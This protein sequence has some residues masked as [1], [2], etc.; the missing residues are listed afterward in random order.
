M[1][2]SWSFLDKKKAAV[3][4]IEAF[5]S[6]EFIINHTDEEILEVRSGLEGV[7]AQN[8][9]GMPKAGDP[10][11]GE[12]RLINGIAEIDVLKER[13][14]QAVEY[15]NW[16]KP[17]WEQLSDDERFVLELFYLSDSTG[18]ADRIA[19]EF[20]IDRK[21]AYNKKYKAEEHLSVLLYGKW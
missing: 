15:M 14:R 3:S 20:G 10:Q 18:A 21:T 11:S 19:E 7:G 4:A 13:Y 16:F 8:L 2:I 9:S 12:D 1:H 6:M 5:T 17:T